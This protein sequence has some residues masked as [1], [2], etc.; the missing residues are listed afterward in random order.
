MKNHSPQTKPNIVSE[1]HA[2]VKVHETSRDRDKPADIHRQE[3]SLEIVTNSK[4]SRL[5]RPAVCICGYEERWHQERWHH[6]ELGC[7]KGIGRR[8][9]NIED[10]TCEKY[11]TLKENKK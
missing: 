8:G 9:A 11:K 2:D 1:H 3:T 6:E 10:C 4:E 5:P 7:C